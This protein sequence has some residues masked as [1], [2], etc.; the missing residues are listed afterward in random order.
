MNNKQRFYMA[1]AH[2]EKFT[3]GMGTLSGSVKPLGDIRLFDTF[4]QADEASQYI[5]GGKC[6]TYPKGM[7]INNR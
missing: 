1:I 7:Y 2:N 3:V 5:A 6:E 4:E